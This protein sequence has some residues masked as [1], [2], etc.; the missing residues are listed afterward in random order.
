MRLPPMYLMDPTPEGYESPNAVSQCPA[1]A[2][3]KWSIMDKISLSCMLTKGKGIVETQ[4]RPRK[5]G[6]EILKRSM[7]QR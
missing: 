4:K 6:G 3:C 2:R 1:A 5:H 7:K